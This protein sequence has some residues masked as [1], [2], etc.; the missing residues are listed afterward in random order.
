MP[1]SP[2]YLSENNLLCGSLF[3]DLSLEETIYTYNGS[4]LVFF[5]HLKKIQC[6]LNDVVLRTPR[7]TAPLHVIHYV[8]IKRIEHISWRINSNIIFNDYCHTFRNPTLASIP[9]QY[10]QVSLTFLFSSASSFVLLYIK[11]YYFIA[12]DAMCS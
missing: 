11:F 2:T 5:L 7:N 1:V 3:T 12:N 6:V 8:P 9:T 4:K 10:P